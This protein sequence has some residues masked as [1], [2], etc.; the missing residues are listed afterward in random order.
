MLNPGQEF[1]VNDSK[2]INREHYIKIIFILMPILNFLNG[3]NIDIYAPAMPYLSL[4]FHTT[5][6]MMKNTISVTIVG[7]FFGA[8]IFGI[9]IDHLGRKKTLILGLVIYLIASFFAIYVTTITQLMMVRFIQGLCTVSMAIGARAVLADVLEGKQL[10]YAII[11]TSIGYGLGPIIGPYIGSLLQEYCSWQ[12]CFYFLTLFSLLMILMVMF[13]VKDIHRV[14]KVLNFKN[15]IVKVKT[16]IQCR[17]LIIG[18]FILGLTQILMLLYSM[19]GPFLVQQSLHLSVSQYGRTALFVGFGY[20]G[21]NLLNRLLLKYLTENI[22]YGIAGGLLI[23]ALILS[24]VFALFFQLNLIN[25]LLPIIL[26]NISAGIIFSNTMAKN[27]RLTPLNIGIM[28]AVQM[29]CLAII[30][31]MGLFITSWVHVTNLWQLSIIY[32]SVIIL[33]LILINSY[34]KCK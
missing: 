15:F 20:L 1:S 6:I 14:N 5:P 28:L 27:L 22:T 12:A 9:L 4:Y 32:L 10:T 11:Y 7:W 23:M 34:V 8:I 33:N 25:I 2:L 30:V 13:F 29:S 19:L 17:P 21:G 16:V 24:F 3:I 26:I 18:I 31:V